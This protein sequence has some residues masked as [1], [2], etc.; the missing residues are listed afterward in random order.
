MFGDPYYEDVHT[1]YDKFLY[2]EFLNKSFSVTNS[3]DLLYKDDTEIN[4]AVI[5][6]KKLIEFK[7]IVYVH[8]L[9]DHNTQKRD[10]IK[11]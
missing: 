9:T 5:L 2:V 6:I 1:L 3:V 10:S 7:Q 11:K 4:R 8:V